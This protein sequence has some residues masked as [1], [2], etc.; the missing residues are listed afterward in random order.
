MVK[1]FKK[2][3]AII[4]TIIF[5]LIL[6][7]IL[8][9]VNLVNSRSNYKET[10]RLLEIQENILYIRGEEVTPPQNSER[11]VS[12]IYS[13]SIGENG[14]G[15]VVFAHEGSTYSDETLIQTAKH[16]RS[17][18]K[19]EGVFERFRYR[20][21]EE[22]GEQIV[23]FLDY[24][25]WQNQQQRLVL[26]STLI[27]VVG[28][29]ILFI[30][31]IFLT[32]WLTKPIITALNKQKQFISDAGHELKTPLTVMKAS[33]EMLENEQRSSKYL[34]YVKEENVRMTGLV[35]EMLSLSSV[36]REENIEKI[37]LS[38]GRVVEGTVLPFESLAYEQGLTLELIGMEE[39]YVLG[40]ELQLKQLIEVLIDNAIK[41]TYPQGKIL[42]EL[43]KEK[44]K[45]VLDVKNQGDKIEEE[46]REK[47]FD[48]FYRIDKAR[49]RQE[50]R[51]GLG[52]SIASSIVRQHKGKIAVKCEDGWTIFSVK[53]PLM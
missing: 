13:V 50:G 21:M 7:G 31:T 11:E 43:K 47:I 39:V 18:N 49:G 51:Y 29:I 46:E 37:R 8:L 17:R 38:L 3:T 5:W 6:L 35:H 42:V 33:L 45:A 34:G 14:E 40:N 41:H 23:S 20:L 36:E 53:L 10:G 16:I 24:S 28:M 32:E 22:E 15:T 9:T 26:Y 25:L 2:K 19:T 1:R 27:G 4:L 52:L 44:G 12:K 48:R 30:A